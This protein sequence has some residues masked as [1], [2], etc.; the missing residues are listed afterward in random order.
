M[1]NLIQVNDKYA[2][3]SDAMNWKVFKKVSVS[4]K[5]PTG[6]EPVAYYSTLSGAVKGLS[7]LMLRTSEENSVAGPV[8]A[9]NRINMLMKETFNLEKL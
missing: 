4:K 3:G 2:I 6:Q 1:A 9:A 8:Q 5:N 7:G